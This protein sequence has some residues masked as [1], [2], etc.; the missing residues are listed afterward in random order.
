MVMDTKP[1]EPY[2]GHDFLIFVGDTSLA[3]KPDDITQLEIQCRN[4]LMELKK[5]F[6]HDIRALQGDCMGVEC[7]EVGCCK[8]L[9]HILQRRG[10]KTWRHFEEGF[11]RFSIFCGKNPMVRTVRQVP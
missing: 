1:F 7:T 4:M 11:S 5:A 10:F 2:L 8:T 3:L 6:K 9:F